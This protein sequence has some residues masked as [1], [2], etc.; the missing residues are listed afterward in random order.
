MQDDGSGAGAWRSSNPWKTIREP[1]IVW[2]VSELLWIGAKMS[3]L[4]KLY[5]QL[6]DLGSADNGDSHHCI[7]LASDQSPSDLTVLKHV[8][9]SLTSMMLMMSIAILRANIYFLP[10]TKSIFA[11]SSQEVCSTSKQLPHEYLVLRL[12]DSSIGAVSLDLAPRFALL[13]ALT[14]VHHQARLM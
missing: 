10:V 9:H 12:M 5:A 11:A 14:K 3:Q 7:L 6:A 1:T 13:C 4:C 8:L 2:R